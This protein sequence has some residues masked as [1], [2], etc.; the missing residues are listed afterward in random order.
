MGKRGGMKMVR[1]GRGKWRVGEVAVRFGEELL[2][3]V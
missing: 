1:G 2:L 3:A